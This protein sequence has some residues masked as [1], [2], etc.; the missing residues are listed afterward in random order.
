MNCQS[1]AQ[2]IEKDENETSD[3]ELELWREVKREIM[4][5]KRQILRKNF[6]DILQLFCDHNKNRIKTFW[7]AG[8]TLKFLSNTRAIKFNVKIIEKVMNRAQIKEDLA[9]AYVTTYFLILP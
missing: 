2:H 6:L 7:A 1:R 3:F 5:K 9:S 8:K 4:R